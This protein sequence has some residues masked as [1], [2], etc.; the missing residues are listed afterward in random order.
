[1]HEEVS[2]MYKVECAAVERLK[3]V[4]L[5]E[6]YFPKPELQIIFCLLELI[7]KDKQPA[8]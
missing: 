7:S 8:W 6:K 4:I 1:M 3:F 2:F 5:D